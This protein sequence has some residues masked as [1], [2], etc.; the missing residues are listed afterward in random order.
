MT[1][2]NK[3]YNYVGFVED[4][5]VESLL[6][7]LENGKI[8]KTRIVYCLGENKYLLRIYGYNLVMHSD[9]NFN[10]FDEV[11][12]QIKQVSPRLIVQLVDKSRNT[13]LANQHSGRM[14][15]IV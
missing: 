11:E 3:K 9:I 1:A 15:V 13:K 5:G 12:V 8:I 2:A 14:D 10:R 7:R 4:S 6:H